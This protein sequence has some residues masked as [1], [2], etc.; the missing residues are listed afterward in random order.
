MICK[1]CNSKNLYKAHYCQNCGYAFTDEDR[2][3]AY[4]KTVYGLFNKLEDLYNTLTLDKITGSIVFKILS[5]VC[6]L[7]IGLFGVITNGNEMKI[8]E[9]EQYEVQY[10]TKTEEYYLLS[11]LDEIGVSL[12]LPKEAEVLRVVELDSDN[13][14]VNED[15]Y[16]M[17]DSIVLEQT[18]NKYEVVAEY[19]NATNEKVVIRVFGK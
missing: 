19:S 3:E 8:L 7:V 16:T 6:V 2:E 10:N 17:E 11:E 14:Q 12:Y 9:S 1:N 13:Q 4:S 18:S 5:I 15:V